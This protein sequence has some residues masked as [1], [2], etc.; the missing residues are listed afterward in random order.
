MKKRFILMVAVVSF[1][2]N[3]G[4]KPSANSDNIIKE[5]EAYVS[6]VNKSQLETKVVEGALTDISGSKDIGRFKLTYYYD[7]ATNTLVRVENI[8]NTSKAVTENFYFENK[9]LL[10]IS[11]K[12]DDA[13][14]KKLYVYKGDVVNSTDLDTDYKKILLD[15]SQIFK[16][17]FRKIDE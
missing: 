7:K 12:T 4:P 2:Y 17:D 15:K 16:R 9:D 3:C 8:E 11:T 14:T 5:R 1:L 6:E 13:G 10:Y